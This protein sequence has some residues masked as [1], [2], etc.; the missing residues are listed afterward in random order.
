METCRLL[1][2]DNNNAFV[3]IAM[4]FLQSQPDL[5][6]VASAESAARGLSLASQLRPEVVVLDL[7]LQQASG[8]DLIPS[9][10]RRLPDVKVIVLTLWSSEPYRQAA[11]AAGADD[12][13]SKDRLHTDLLPAIR[14]LLRP[15]APVIG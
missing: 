13:V 15:T 3:R 5:G 10:R 8:L 2:V 7:H 1:L 14:R 12:F 9:L 11:L 4:R 6:R